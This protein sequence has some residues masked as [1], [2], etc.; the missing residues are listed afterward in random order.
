MSKRQRA[1]WMD[2][3]PM[4]RKAIRIYTKLNFSRKDRF[5]MKKDRWKQIWNR[6]KNGVV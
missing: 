5:K 4:N 3:E 1:S 2:G 6:K